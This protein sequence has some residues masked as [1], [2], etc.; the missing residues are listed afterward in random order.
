MTPFGRSAVVSFS[1][2]VR[3]D[4]ARF[5]YRMAKPARTATLRRSNDANAPRRDLSLLNNEYPPR[6]PGCQQT[7]QGRSPRLTREPG[8]QGA[9]RRG[10]R[11]RKN[12]AVNGA[13]TLSA[14]P[15]T[16]T[17]AS[18]FSG[19]RTFARS[20]SQKRPR[21]SRKCL[22]CVSAGAQDPG[23]VTDL[24]SWK[25][26]PAGPF[27]SGRRD[28]NSGPLV[29]QTSALTRLRHAPWGTRLA[30]FRCRRVAWAA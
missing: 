24:S 5:E 21:S 3:R 13:L 22:L 23:R 14:P 8:R 25:R 18:R 30:A 11:P 4:P 6:F 17:P 26:P 20:E 12:G 29:P 1:P 19:I 9:P 7:G 16:P 27:L 10:G 2:S 15:A 28:L